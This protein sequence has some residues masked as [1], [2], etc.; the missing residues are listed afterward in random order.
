MLY[1]SKTKLFIIY[2]IIS[3]LSLFALTNFSENKENFLLSKQIN[4]GLDLQGGSYLLLEVD[5]K[6]LINQR[7]Q[8][9]SMRSIGFKCFQHVVTVAVFLCFQWFSA[10]Q[11][12][13][14]LE[15]ILKVFRGSAEP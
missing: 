11:N 5:S 1:F 4:L 6:P 9:K 8:Q 15:R 10:R 7:L 13:P 14:D 12:Y 2:L 3:F